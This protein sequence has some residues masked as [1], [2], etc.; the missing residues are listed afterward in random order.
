MIKIFLVDDQ[1]SIRKGLQMQMALESDFLVMGETGDGF[2]ALQRIAELKPDVVILDIDMPGMDGF[3]TLQ[4]LRQQEIDVPIVILSIQADPVS[5]QRAIDLGA[6][7]FVE[8]QAGGTELFA[9]IRR[10][11]EG[12]QQSQSR[13]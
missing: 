5:R 6:A 2:T 13:R 9:A 1:P 4:A 10:A 12:S 11:A 7:D 8:K 3:E